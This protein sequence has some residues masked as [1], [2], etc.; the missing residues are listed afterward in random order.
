MN[1][2]RKLIPGG[3]GNCFRIQKSKC[4]FLSIVSA[5]LLAGSLKRGS[6]MR[7]SPH[8]YFMHTCAS[9]CFSQQAAH[10]EELLMENE[11]DVI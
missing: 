7:F 8:A 3:L 1:H 2:W 11:S 9:M 6:W 10:A 5:V 4:Y